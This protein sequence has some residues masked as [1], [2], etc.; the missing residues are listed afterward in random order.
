[1][2]TYA[3]EVRALD[4][5]AAFLADISSGRHP[6]RPVQDVRAEAARLLLHWPLGPAADWHT[7]RP[8][9]IHIPGAQNAA[10]NGSQ[11]A[12]A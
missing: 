12:T 2:S 9:Q 3:Q 6:L 11:E 4:A 8:G 1:M 10:Q 5:V 7:P